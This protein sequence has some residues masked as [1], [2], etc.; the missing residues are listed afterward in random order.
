[1]TLRGLC[2]YYL[3]CLSIDNSGVV[4]ALVRGNTLNYA[5][6]ETV[7]FT[8]IDYNPQINQLLSK[9]QSNDIVYFGY[10]VIVYQNK[11]APIFLYQ[12]NVEN[13]KID[14]QETV[15]SINQGVIRILSQNDQ[16]SH[17]FELLALEK[18]IGFDAENPESNLKEIIRRLVAARTNWP[19][20]EDIN[21]DI[22]NTNIQIMDIQKPGIYNKAII[23]LSANSPY[24]KGLINELNALSGKSENEYRDTALYQWIHNDTFV[25]SQATEIE[26][27]AVLPLNAEQKQAVKTALT[28]Q[29]TIVT[30]PPG[31]GKSQVVINA[32]INSAWWGKTVLFAS[33]NNKAV[34]VVEERVNNLCDRPVLLRI[35]ANANAEKLKKI[36]QDLL[37]V[38][39]SKADIE[40]YNSAFAEYKEKLALRKELENRKDRIIN[41]RN[42]LDDL[43]QGIEQYRQETVGLWNSSVY[44]QLPLFKKDIDV[45]VTAFL[46]VQKSRQ[47]FFVRLFWIF[48]RKFREREFLFSAEILNRVLVS[49]NLNTVSMSYS[50]SQCTNIEN[51]ITAAKMRIE[52]LEAVETYTKA[53][54]L[55]EQSETLEEIDKKIYDI[56][57]SLTKCAGNVW[58]LWMLTQASPVEQSDRA[59]L[60]NY[61]TALKLNM[62]NNVFSQQ[63]TVIMN[64]LSHVAAKYIPCWAVTALS[65]KGR[66]PLSSG[67][68]D[69]LIIDEASQCDIAS[70]IPLLFRAKRAVII[71]DPNQ[72]SHITNISKSQDT[73]LLFKHHIPP[74]YF[75]YSY[76]V[77]SLYGLA[78]SI[79]KPEN[80]IK[81]RDHHRSHSDI[82]NYSNKEFYENKLRVATRYDRLFVPAGINPGLYWI[83]V[84]GK[85]E[86]P[87]N[88]SAI[89]YA[90]A[91]K[92]IDEL[93]RLI[94]QDNY[95]GSVG[96]VTPFRAQADYIRDRIARN[97]ELQSVLQSRNNFLVDTVHKFQGDERDVLFFSPVVAEGI[98]KGAIN[99]LCNT[100]NLFN[101]AITRARAV[102]FVVGD[103]NYCSHCGVRYMENFVVYVNSLPKTPLNPKAQL[104]TGSIY[105]SV[106]N[107]EEV[108]DWEKQLYS[109]LYK[110]GITVVP[111]Y[112][113]EQ[114]RLDFALFDGQRQLDIEVDGEMYHKDWTGELCYRDQIRNHRL[115]E[116]NWD[117]MRFWVYQI[118]DDIDWCVEQVHKW[119]KR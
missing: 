21:P 56:R 24:V 67:L 61:L 14:I 32:L 78:E 22:L 87:K 27:I 64:N 53:L 59:Q 91:H 108:S 13:N 109:A 55:T 44:A 96:V 17:T 15:P 66:I 75:R 97:T 7:N 113:V 101:V 35:G 98:S 73:S 81:L 72:L 19:W 104:P 5:E 36:V 8:N 114:Y 117:V 4:E 39:V 93:S 116:M 46:R 82:I 79:A 18:E 6:I 90:E 70:V 103:N 52:A 11:V 110:K 45:F 10:P 86:Q 40:E 92:V 115:Y 38:S 47:P 41:A 77:T 12:I 28:E 107:P 112:S 9:A 23:I 76:S 54:K 29:L 25:N 105:P 57:E 34:D 37:S 48:F 83:A 119:M 31:T 50:D 84:T 30:G 42:K 95:H 88:R 102:L 71:G 68:F 118:R 2:Q 43:E 33:K 58:R 1:M 111:Q 74:D 49:L 89:N 80:I 60:Q 63:L 62:N 100:G 85:T 3:H 26:P 94:L 51:C 99:F 106:S 16:D 65:V 20:I 69:L